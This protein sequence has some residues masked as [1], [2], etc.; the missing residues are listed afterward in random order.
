MHII[1]FII[2]YYSFYIIYYI[3]YFNVYYYFN[4]NVNYETAVTAR[5]RIGWM[6]FREYSKI[7][8]KAE[9]FH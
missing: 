7:Y 8:L 2:L 5:S 1:I 4:F 3:I 9:G 6:K